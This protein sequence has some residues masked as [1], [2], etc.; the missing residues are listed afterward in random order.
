MYGLDI[1]LENTNDPRISGKS[2]KGNLK[3]YW[4]YRVGNYRIIA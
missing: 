2:I 3:D 1:N 4:R